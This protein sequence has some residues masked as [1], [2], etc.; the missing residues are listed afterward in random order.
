MVPP[1]AHYDPADGVGEPSK[2]EPRPPGPMEALRSDANGFI[3]HYDGSSSDLF[4][5]IEVEHSITTETIGATPMEE[6]CLV[7]RIWMTGV[8]DLVTAEET[9]G[10]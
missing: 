10:R 4:Q 6:A 2:G 8:I 5:R 1:L 3:V 7:N 9:A